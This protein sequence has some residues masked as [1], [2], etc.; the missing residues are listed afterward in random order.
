MNKNKEAT[1][2][3]NTLEKNKPFV[4]P[5]YLR[6][7]EQPSLTEEQRRNLQHSI[8]EDLARY[9]RMRESRNEHEIEINLETKKKNT[10]K[11]STRGDK[12][13]V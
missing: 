1:N 4:R 12:N 3:E 7:W 10:I 5:K 6:P 9:K 8:D 2:A 11:Q 13:N